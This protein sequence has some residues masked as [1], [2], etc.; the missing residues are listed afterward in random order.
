MVW[1]LWQL[2]SRDCLRYVT[3]LTVAKLDASRLFTAPSWPTLC[4]IQTL[5]IHMMPCNDC[6]ASAAVNNVVEVPYPRIAGLREV[7]RG[8]PHL[9]ITLHLVVIDGEP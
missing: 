7:L 2:A 9:L 4:S 5:M 8:G 3:F 6:A 1:R